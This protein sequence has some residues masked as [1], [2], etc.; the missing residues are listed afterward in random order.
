MCGGQ[1][2]FSFGNANCLFRSCGYQ[3]VTLYALVPYALCKPTN[4][5]FQFFSATPASPAFL[6]SSSGHANPIALRVFTAKLRKVL[7]RAGLPASKFS[8]HNFRRG[9]ATFA[10]RCG[11]PLELISLQGNWS[12]DAVLLYIAQLLDRRLSVAS[13]IDQTMHPPLRNL[14]VYFYLSLFY[15]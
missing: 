4:V 11:E 12:S 1:K 7:S 9:G 13:L 15:V 8:G 5:T 10:F 2:Q 14:F 6:H 3:R